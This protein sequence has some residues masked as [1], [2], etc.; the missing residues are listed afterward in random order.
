MYN[1]YARIF[2]AV[3]GIPAGRVATYGQI[4]ESAGLPGQA[5]LVGY[6]LHRCPP[7]LQW[8]RVINARGTISLPVDSTAAITQR[9]RLMDE[10]VVFL[11]SRVDLGRFG[12]RG[13]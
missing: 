12:W 3:R 13:G 9:R 7:G 10:G 4:A 1:S 2:D 11:G 6:A 5:R 8:H